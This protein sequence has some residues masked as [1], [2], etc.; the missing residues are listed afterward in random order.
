[1]DHKRKYF[2]KDMNFFIIFIS[3][4]FIQYVHVCVWY[5]GHIFYISVLRT[6]YL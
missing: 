1:M 2:S 6:F 5:S 3:A 4:L